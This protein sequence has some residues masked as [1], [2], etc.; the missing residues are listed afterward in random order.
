LERE[1]RHLP[2]YASRLSVDNRIRCY[3]KGMS[4][5]RPD[6]TKVGGAG[7]SISGEMKD[8]KYMAR[9]AHIVRLRWTMNKESPEMRCE[10]GDKDNAGRMRSRM[11][12]AV[13]WW[14]RREDALGGWNRFRMEKRVSSSS[15]DD[16]V[17]R[18][19][20]NESSRDPHYF[21]TRVRLR[22]RLIQHPDCSL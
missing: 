21:P 4:S 6:E 17:S 16:A 19:A 18:D 12:Q 22:L 11:N 7:G 3:D 14:G 1:C 20:E 15:S 8:T 5:S 13:L 2:D 9:E 10:E